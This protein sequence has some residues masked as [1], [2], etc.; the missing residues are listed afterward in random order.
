MDNE[1]RG[2]AIVA[3]VAQA[4]AA[5]LAVTSPCAALEAPDS[6]VSQEQVEP[7]ISRDDWRE[8]IQEA[9]RRAKEAAVERR[10]NP[11]PYVVTPEDPERIATDRVMNDDSL[12]RGDIVSTKKGLFMFK[13]RSDQPRRADDFVALPR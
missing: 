5:C 13:G 12:Q 4:F 9:R 8:R 6:A 10:N 11:V 3:I 1:R 2:T 7:E